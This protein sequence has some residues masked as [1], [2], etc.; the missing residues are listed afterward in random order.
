MAS[1]LRAKLRA[2]RNATPA[3]PATAKA[4]APNVA[5]TMAPR[6]NPAS[7]SP[8]T[9]IAKIA[10][11]VP[12]AITA[13][14]SEARKSLVWNFTMRSFRWLFHQLVPKLLDC[15]QRPLECRQFFTQAAYMH[16]HGS[17][18]ACIFVPPHVGQQCVAREHAALVLQQI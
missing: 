15:D 4:S 13:V 3:E 7:A 2:I 17:G 14:M 9:A 5:P 10:A 11:A 16:V 1:T 18:A 6:P 12:T 8:R